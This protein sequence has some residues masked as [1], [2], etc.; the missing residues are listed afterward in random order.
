VIGA[1]SVPGR[2]SRFWFTLPAPLARAG[3]ASRP[4]AADAPVSLMGARV[5]VVDDHPANRELARLFLGG[6]GAEVTEAQDGETAV[7]IADRTPFDAILMDMRMP[8]LDGVGA[9]RLIRTGDGPNA[10]TP[11]V[12][13]TAE[14]NRTELDRLVHEGFAAIVVKPV[15]PAQL[16]AAV[17]EALAIEPGPAFSRQAG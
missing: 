12:A 9:L 15:V 14:A 16:L 13:Y 8:K 2:G 11:I 6:C 10:R 4:Q 5:L 3:A 7:A 1:E 17:A